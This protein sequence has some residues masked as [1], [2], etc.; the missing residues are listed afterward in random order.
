MT[1]LMRARHCRIQAQGMAC[2][3]CRI[4]TQGMACHDCRIQTQGMACHDLQPFITVSGVWTKLCQKLPKAE[5]SSEQTFSVFFFCLH[6]Y[7]KEM[8]N[9]NKYHRNSLHTTRNTVCREN[10]LSWRRDVIAP[11]HLFRVY[12]IT[13]ETF[14]TKNDHRECT[15]IPTTGDTHARHEIVIHVLKKGWK[16][17]SHKGLRAGYNFWRI[18]LSWHM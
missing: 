11:R 4:Q 5:N 12:L 3:D 16:E 2:H 6:G 17:Y 13:W 9:T 1:D 15:Y 8:R 10:V 18:E 7:M 14:K